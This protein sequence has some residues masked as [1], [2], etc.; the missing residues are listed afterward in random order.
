[1]PNFAIHDGATVSNVIVA[2]SQ[3]VAESITGLSAIDVSDDGEP[4]IGWT[5]ESEGW[6][7][8]SPYPSWVWGGSAWEAPV[9][10]PGDGSYWDEDTLSWIAPEPE[11]SAP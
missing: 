9:A 11:E 6:R 8:P 1:M 2:D 4:W 7:A 5:M 3:E 10:D